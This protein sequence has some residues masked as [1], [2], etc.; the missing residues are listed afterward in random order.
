MHSREKCPGQ[1]GRSFPEK[2]GLSP[3]TGWTF[4]TRHDNGE[5]TIHARCKKGTSFTTGFRAR[6]SLVRNTVS[7]RIFAQ[8]AA[9]RGLARVSP[10]SNTLNPQRSQSVSSN[11]C[12]NGDKLSVPI[13]AQRGLPKVPLLWEGKP[14]R[15]PGN[16]NT[17]RGQVARR[18]HYGC[19][20]K[21]AAV[22]RCVL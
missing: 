8:G 20:T 3:A 10:Y 18:V 7:R 15:W 9:T 11:A 17:G 21:P 6:L 13:R 19:T 12:S 5:Q 4:D 14:G 1:S 2:V 22:G 16:T